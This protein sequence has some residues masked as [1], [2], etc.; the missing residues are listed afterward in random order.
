[1]LSRGCLKNTLVQ[2]GRL[3]IFFRLRLSSRD[4]STN[5]SG[6]WTG[7]FVQ[8]IW[9]DER[10]GWLTNLGGVRDV[11]IFY[12]VFN[13]VGGMRSTGSG[14]RK[15]RRKSNKIGRS[16]RWSGSHEGESLSAPE[17]LEIKT[18]KEMNHTILGQENWSYKSQNFQGWVW[19]W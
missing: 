18:E 2:A 5:T 4:G 15:S 19:L 17:V 3:D 10:V 11:G 9:A 14:Q 6:K 8:L 1:M 16:W 7:A 13:L 12:K